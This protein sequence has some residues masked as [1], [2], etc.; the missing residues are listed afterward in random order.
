MA[1]V[2]AL[3]GPAAS[4]K[5]S[6]H[7]T[8]LWRLPHWLLTRDPEHKPHTP[9]PDK[10]VLVFP[11][12]TTSGDFAR[13]VLS[14][15]QISEAVLDPAVFLDGQPPSPF[16]MTFAPLHELGN[17]ISSV[18]VYAAGMT[19]QDV[20]AL[21][22]P[23]RRQNSGALFDLTSESAATCYLIE[24]DLTQGRLSH[25]IQLVSEYRLPDMV[26]AATPPGSIPNESPGFLPFMFNSDVSCLID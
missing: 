12:D 5:G 14:A 24:L 23:S 3:C 19:Q 11:K 10:S 21:I 25:V 1:V 22:F 9:P 4:G 6:H 20:T 13:T 26:E 2:L 16:A 18:E 8:L 17:G 15:K 7:V